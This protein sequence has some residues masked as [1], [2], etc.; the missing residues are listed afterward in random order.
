M[1]YRLKIAN[2]PYPTPFS[3]KFEN[4][5]FALDLDLD[6]TRIQMDALGHTLTPF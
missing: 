5:P 6:S 1:T 4:V 2:F 3:P